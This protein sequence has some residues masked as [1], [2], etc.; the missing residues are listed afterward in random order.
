MSRSTVIAPQQS[1]PVVRRHWMRGA[2]A[3]LLAAALVLG[4]GQLVSVFIDPASSPF[5]VL[6]ATMVDHT[7]HTLKDA[8]IRRFGSND[9]LALFISMSVVMAIGAALVG[10]LERRRPLG[11]PMLLLL[12][13]VTALFALQRPTA[14]V[15]FVLPTVAGIAAGIVALRLVVA[16][17]PSLRTPESANMTRR[18]FL[19]TAVSVGALAVGTVSAARWLGAHLRDVVADRARFLLPRPLRSALAVPPEAQPQ[20]AGLT[21]FITPDDRFY[22]VDTALQ[23]PALTSGD[24]RLRIHGMTD[25]TVELDFD[26]LRQRTA[27]ERIL[28]LTCV[29]NEVGG[30]LAGTARWLGYPLAD[31]LADAGVHP[32]ADMLL[33]RSID[34]FT[35]GTPLSAVLDGRDA[36]LVIGMNGAPLPIAHGYPARLIVPGLYGYVSAT[37]WVVDLEITR[38][39]RASAYWTDRGW[40]DHGPIKTASRIDVPAAFATVPAGAVTVAGV[41]WAQQRGIASI[42]VQVDDQPWQPA[43]PAAEYSIDTWRQWTWQWMAEAG[44][45]T[46]RVRAT[47]RSGQLQSEQRT[48][49]FPSGS[50]GWHSRMVTVR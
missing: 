50:T 5:F 46:L 45:H 29:S 39:D 11:T 26:G 44:N 12:G 33:S 32:D 14:T 18:R 49:P 42:E 25:R 9:K 22:R 8:A 17:T 1:S 47:D 21:P 7:P 31:L 15:W 34:G 19:I 24:W 35:V 48:P 20:I 43:T 41:A 40:A 38:F 23:L 37:K 10:M 3:G 13:G 30:E 2:V 6:G 28:T 16:G 36:L 4:A 27:V